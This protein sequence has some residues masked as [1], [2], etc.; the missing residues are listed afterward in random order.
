MLN[1]NIKA[2]PEW[3][4]QKGQ[5]FLTRKMEEVR[6]LSL[7]EKQNLQSTL[8]PGSLQTPPRL[9]ASSSGRDRSVGSRTKAAA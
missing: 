7:S 2:L 4:G 8:L 1:G 3:V 6:E 5:T 9:P